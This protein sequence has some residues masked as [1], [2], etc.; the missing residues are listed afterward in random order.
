M[1]W[2]HH[3]QVMT[4]KAAKMLKRTLYKCDSTVKATAYTT[5]IRPTLE[6]AVAVWDPHQQYLIDSIERIQR[7]A[8]RWTIMVII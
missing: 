3:I 4:Q 2:N 6:Y 8:V 5:V 7:R 1:S